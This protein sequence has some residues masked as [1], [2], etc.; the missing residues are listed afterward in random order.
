VQFHETEQSL[1]GVVGAYRASSLLDG[2]SDVDVDVSS[3]EFI[4]VCV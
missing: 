4:D 1:V 3:L 2:D